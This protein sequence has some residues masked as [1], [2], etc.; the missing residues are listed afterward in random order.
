MQF[1]FLLIDKSPFFFF[2]L[3]RG[4]HPVPEADFIS[5]ELK[6]KNAINTD[7]IGHW[8]K[9]TSCFSLLV[10]QK[11]MRTL[12]K[13]ILNSVRARCRNKINWPDKTWEKKKQRLHPP[14]NFIVMWIKDNRED[15]GL[16]QIM[17]F[18]IVLSTKSM[19]EKT[20]CLWFIKYLFCFT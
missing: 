14:E 17:L 16:F 1:Q 9:W 13:T 12:M 11:C 15:L 20:T 2:F 3:H 4:H 10:K 8:V 19:L 7:N 18:K 6:N 5:I